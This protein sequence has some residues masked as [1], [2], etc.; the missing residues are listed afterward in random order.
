MARFP[1]VRLTF[2]QNHLMRHCTVFLLALSFLFI[3]KSPAQGELA[4][5]GSSGISLFARGNSNIA[6][7]VGFNVERGLQKNLSIHGILAFDAGVG[8]G[9][10][11]TF[12]ISPEVRYNFNH[13]LDGPYIG[14]FVGFGPTSFSGFYI[15]VGAAGGYKF[16]ITEHFNIDAT[17]QVGMG[18]AGNALG[19]VT[20][21]HFR[22][23]AALRYA[24]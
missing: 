10:F 20:G 22:P 11:N 5:G 7:P 6:V 21:L 18:N 24:F 23:T 19:R 16:P 3:Q 9:D 15:S 14:G 8:R 2:A 1:I 17:V 4:V 13:A 12:Y